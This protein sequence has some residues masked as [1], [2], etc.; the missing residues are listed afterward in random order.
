MQITIFYNFVRYTFIS[1]VLLAVSYYFYVV[2]YF[3]HLC[4]ATYLQFGFPYKLGQISIVGY[5][6]FF[7]V[8]VL[9]SLSHRSVQFQLVQVRR[10]KSRRLV[11]KSLWR[12]RNS[13][14]R[15]CSSCFRNMLLQ[16]QVHS[17]GSLIGQG[18]LRKTLMIR[19]SRRVI[20]EISPKKN[21]VAS[22]KRKRKHQDDQN[23]QDRVTLHPSD[24]NSYP[25]EDMP[26]K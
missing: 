24:L 10:S 22:R 25:S 8:Y 19:H 1:Y 6:G 21:P 11:L 5:F 13:F 9:W 4:A 15:I 20:T 23:S 17:P 12:L 14:W 26:A 16:R 7:V 18:L 2:P 3:F